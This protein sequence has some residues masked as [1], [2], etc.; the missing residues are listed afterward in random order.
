MT[1]RR[2]AYGALV[3][4]DARGK[5]LTRL[6][7]PTYSYLS[8]NDPR[9]HFGLGGTDHVD[10]LEVLWPSGRKERFA[11]GEIDRE[12]VIQDGDGEEL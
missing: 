8:S 6:A 4:I 7:H 12:I 1:G 10:S 3:T 9:A 11:V 5:R 2:D